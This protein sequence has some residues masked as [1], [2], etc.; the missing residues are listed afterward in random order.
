VLPLTEELTT[1]LAAN[2]LISVGLAIEIIRLDETEFHLA[3]VCEATEIDGVTYE[4]AEGL[5]VA[6]IATEMNGGT[7]SLDLKVAAAATGTLINREDLRDGVFD[8]ARVRIS[9]FELKQ[10]SGLGVL[11]VGSI[12]QVEFTDYGA[13]TF[14]CVGILDD[15]IALAVEHRTPTCRN[16][17]GDDRCG[18]DLEPLGVATTVS[19]AGGFDINVA[20]VGGQ[21]DD[22]FKLGLAE[23]TSGP[24]A[25][26]F[27]ELREQ[28]GTALLTYI[29][30]DIALEPGDTL[31][32]FP[33]CDLTNGP[34][35]C[36][37]WANCINQQADPFVP[38]QDARNI[39]YR[40]WGTPEPEPEGP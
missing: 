21:P 29:P 28:T 33:G 31:T 14:D 6:S 25:G 23:I 12:R 38:G 15:A 8:K 34:L 13:A 30:L 37:R 17:F 40:E 9:L 24:G 4:P 39:N 1:T 26:R 2:D 19:S 20:G 35:G 7:T 5:E 27:Y 32:L 22:Y 3:E 10:D 11:F 16:E 36:L 18:V